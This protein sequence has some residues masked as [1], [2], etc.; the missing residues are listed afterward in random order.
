MTQKNFK[1]SHM[2]SVL[3]CHK[4]YVTENTSSK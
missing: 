4:N 1:K 3:W 2:P